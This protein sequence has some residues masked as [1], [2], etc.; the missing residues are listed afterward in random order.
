MTHL[1][2]LQNLSW[3]HDEAQHAARLGAVLIST[4]GNIPAL[5]ISGL[6]RQAAVLM[7][8]RSPRS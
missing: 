4:V 2:E 3:Q 7:G 1:I 6:I 5:W 8:L